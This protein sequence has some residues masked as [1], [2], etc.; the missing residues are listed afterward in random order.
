MQLKE[1][2]DYK[3]QFVKDLLTHEELVTLIDPNHMYANPK[4]MVYDTVNPYEFY[5]ETIEKGKVY[6]C[7][8]VDVTDV[9]KRPYYGLALYIW[10][11]AHKSV[12][13]LPSGGVRTD[14]ICA[15]I[16]NVISGSRLY[17]L[18][19]LDLDYAKRFAPMADYTGKV[20]RYVC[21]DFYR[22]NDPT[23][24]RPTNRKAGE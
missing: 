21:T 17:G 15:E 10:V 8:D 5:P 6:V 4:D 3:N 24:P 11:F 14:A 9:G 23:K 2:F 13:Q 12:L 19:K 16:D 1:F 18:G 20:L 22:I 7:C